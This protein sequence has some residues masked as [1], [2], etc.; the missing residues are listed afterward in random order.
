MIPQEEC[1]DEQRPGGTCVYFLLLL[2]FSVLSII[3]LGQYL[4]PHS[5]LLLITSPL[6]G[7]CSYLLL[8]Q[9]QLQG[10]LTASLNVVRW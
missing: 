6:G 9:R 3:P 10:S 8:P 5:K 1:R 7:V 4:L 2:G